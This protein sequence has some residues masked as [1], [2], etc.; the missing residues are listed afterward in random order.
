[1]FRKLVRIPVLRVVA[2]A[3]VVGG[4]LL[5]AC[6][7]STPSGETTTSMPGGDT[8]TTVD[9]NASLVFGKGTLPE[10][11]PGSFPIPAQSVVGA[12]MID[13]NRSLTEFVMTLPANVDAVVKFYEDNL[14]A[15]GYE[16]SNSVG[17]DAVWDLEFSGEGVEGDVNIRTAGSGLA[18]VAV[19][20]TTPG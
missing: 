16:V 11:V 3:L 13:R 7:S 17:T 8:T 20:F 18:Y 6:D 15:R 4:L 9:P 12:T 10:T 1:M 19:S 5:A 14:P 2:I